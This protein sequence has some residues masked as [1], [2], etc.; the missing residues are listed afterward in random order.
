MKD[1]EIFGFTG[2]L[3]KVDLSQDKIS[4]E[5]INIDYTT[6]FLGGAGY[7][8]RYLIDKLDKDTDGLGS[9]NTLMIMNGPFTLTGAPSS[10]RFVVCSKSPYTNLWGEANCGGSFG[11]EL[12]KAGF[13]GIIITG[14]SDNPVYL[15]IIDDNVNLI[16]ASSL[17]GKGIKETRF[18]LKN[19]SNLPKAKVLCIGQAGENQVKYANINAEGRSAGRTGMGAVLGS[20]NLKAIIVKGSLFKPKIY[21]P[22]E[23]RASIKK[24][25]QSILNS[26]ITQILRDMGTSAGVMGAYSLGD[27][28]IKYWSKGVWNNISD[29]S[30]ENLKE[31]FLVKNKSCHGCTIGCGRIVNIANEYY[32]VPLCEGP[33]YETIA[34]FGS[35]I[36]NN[37]LESI[38]IA[39]DM[40]N[41]Y[42]LDTISTSSSISLLFD[43]FNKGTIN[44]DQV[45]N[46]NL[47]WGKANSMLT[48][49]KKITF[50][51]GIGQLLAEGSNAIGAKFN[52]SSD[53]IATVN[54]LEVPYHDVRFCHGMALTYAFSPRGA[55]HTSADGFKAL[56]KSVEIDFSSLGIKKVSMNSNNEKMIKGIIIL[57]DYRSLYS[58]LI[59]CF[60]ANPPP[61]YMI[62]LIN[63]LIGSNLDIESTKILGERIFTLKRLFNIK[64]GIK[65]VNDTIPKIL[66]TPLNEGPLKG[67]SPEFK[68]MKKSYYNLRDWNENTGIPNSRI[69]KKLGLTSLKF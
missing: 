53:N 29:I 4:F 16:D 31:K 36:L 23:F 42:G 27:L 5:P 34:G 11:P 45:D 12:K 28:P 15:Q 49:I 44:K 63:N 3:L 2:V 26:S 59:S 22:H 54:K 13:D 35:M 61:E 33:E 66:L 6:D 41:D 47:L 17:W 37:D 46:L 57:Q 24:T 10:N 14:K 9:Q 39:N 65:P 55:C 60:F 25:L 20:K 48:L 18:K 43:L 69:I 40:C 51:D 52:I 32:E 30:G 1:Q 56:R 62:G 50:K 19:L 68:K 58:S 67:S 7:A 38:S 64:M 8:C 21:S